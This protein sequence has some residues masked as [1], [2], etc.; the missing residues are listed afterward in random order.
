M[1]NYKVQEGDTPDSLAEAFQT[2]A[3]K[4]IYEHKANE[5][6]RSKRGPNEIQPGDIVLIPDAFSELTSGGTNTLLASEKLDLL[7]V[8]FDAHMHIMS[9]NCT[10]FPVAYF[11]QLEPVLNGVFGGK[12]NFLLSPASSRKILN[13]V[14]STMLVSLVQPF[15]SWS[16]RS[17]LRIGQDTIEQNDS[18]FNVFRAS[19]KKYNLQHL[20]DCGKSFLGISIVL[21]MDMDLC[22]LDG[23]KGEPVYTEHKPPGAKKAV[24]TYNVRLTGEVNERRD[25]GAAHPTEWG[26]FET[27]DEQVLN[28]KI[29]CAEHPLRLIPMYHYEPRRFSVW[30]GQETSFEQA[31][32]SPKWKEPFA[33]LA[34]KSQA[35]MFAGFK[36]YTSQGYQ[37][38]DPRVPS[39]AEFFKAC[40]DESIPIMTHCTP[41]GHFTHE[42]RIF[43]DLDPAAASKLSQRDKDDYAAAREKRNKYLDEKERFTRAEKAFD[44][45][46]REHGLPLDPYLYQSTGVLAPELPGPP[47]PND[48]EYWKA[49][50]E[51]EDSRAAFDEA[52][53][54]YERAA[55]SIRLHEDMA[56][57]LVRAGGNNQKMEED[58]PLRLKYFKE[59]YLH[60]EAWRPLLEKHN[61][62]RLCL[63][64]FASD[65]CIWWHYFHGEKD[66][67][68]DLDD[69]S[70]EKNWVQ[71]IVEL[72]TN[73]SYEN[74]YTDLSYLPLMDP[75]K[76]FPRRSE[77]ETAALKKMEKKEMLPFHWQG[78]AKAC[79]QPGMLKKIM[80]GTDWYMILAS[81]TGYAKWHKEALEGLAL[82]EKE[83]KLPR[84]VNLFYQFAVVNPMRFYRI[85]L[86]AENLVKGIEDFISKAPMT[87]QEKEE[88][89]GKSKE[90]L[91]RNHDL[92]KRLVPVLHQVENA[93]NKKD[94][95]IL[96]EDQV[97]F[98]TV[99]AP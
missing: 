40:A 21:T 99:G 83:L 29:A 64:H 88:H 70:Y 60:P 77:S 57:R 52:G 46:C 62:L 35:G 63:A 30:T 49:Y 72:C 37:P 79:K 32:L 41:S 11:T 39:L 73:E 69:V 84:K 54:A 24:Y 78:L 92:V 14:G 96:Y 51:Y 25:T 20:R 71:S 19:S 58:P 98:V 1:K 10:P 75:M 33:Q 76:P 86:I 44:D 55:R 15:L 42:R 56:A 97:R 90:R 89:F 4:N 82:V 3:W 59:K 47:L 91:A 12:L 28:T 36:M 68:M 48:P 5:D 87:E 13:K 80:F 8:I 38:M 66:P 16:P 43:I 94:Q 95:G 23:Y 61:K 2:K 85:P 31:S 9:A 22:H 18:V 34:T 93:P 7:P 26:L 67:C 53:E 17:T 45:Y 81:K 65:A 27:W 50:S 74:F 6:L